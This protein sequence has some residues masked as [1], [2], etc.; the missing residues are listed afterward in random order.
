MENLSKTMLTK[1]V[2][3][4]IFEW[5]CIQQTYKFGHH[6]EETFQIKKILQTIGGRV[7]KS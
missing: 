3:S 5:G 1:Y 7:L 6:A 2:W 4:S